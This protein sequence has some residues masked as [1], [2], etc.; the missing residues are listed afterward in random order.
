LEPEGDISEKTAERC[1]FHMENSSEKD[2][3]SN[4]ARRYCSLVTDIPYQNKT[5]KGGKA[6]NTLSR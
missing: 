2:T 3:F 4:K 6:G 1:E 5:N